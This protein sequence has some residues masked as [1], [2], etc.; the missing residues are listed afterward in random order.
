MYTKISIERRAMSRRKQIGICC[1]CEQYGKLSYE[2][3][4]PKAAFNKSTVIQYSWQNNHTE[5]RKSKGKSIQ[6]GFGAYTLCEQCNPN[7]GH[8]Y[9]DEYVTWARIGNDLIKI[10]EQRGIKQ[11]EFGLPNVFP[12]RFLKQV[13]VMAFSEI[14]R[15]SAKPDA[16]AKAYPA[17]AQFALNKYE[18][19]LPDGFRFWMN[20]Y[21]PIDGKPTAL[22]H[23]ILGAKIPVVY[24]SSTAHLGGTPTILD[25]EI[26]HPP[27]WLGMTSEN[28]PCPNAQE[29]TH[30]KACGYDDTANIILN[31]RFMDSSLPHPGA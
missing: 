9:G 2:H 31:L 17:L 19:A 21:P 28:D 5:L 29:I 25:A 4:P 7:T 26:A 14:S 12:L 3:I 16:F 6:G 30:F 22:R 27:F 23:N 13:V 20:F 18:Q 10:W 24:N 8:W 11:D 1:L 15:E